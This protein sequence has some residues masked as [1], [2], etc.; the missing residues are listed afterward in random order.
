MF[1]LRAEI[2]A[3]LVAVSL[4]GLLVGWM[5]QRALSSRRLL[6][7]DAAWNA[8][9]V[10][11]ER[12]CEQDVANMEDRLQSIAADMKSLREEN[13]HLTD[14]VRKEV[15]LAETA[16]TEST[17]LAEQ[18]A[19]LQ[20]RL[21]DTLAERDREITRLHLRTASEESPADELEPRRLASRQTN[22]DSLDET[23]RID[24][25]ELPAKVTT[26]R[27]IVANHKEGSVV[28]GKTLDKTLDVG[29]LDTEE[30]TIALDD[31]ALFHMHGLHQTSRK[32]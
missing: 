14:S 18:N 9:Y 1:T 17:T 8:R 24:P 20:E 23:V 26:D 22:E 3:C 4:L 27:G 30:S 16:R 7:A 5:M 29:L 6:D 12:S 11:L 2:A 19:I 10:E 13:R 15:A 32:I 31:E 21:Q 28:M 25:S